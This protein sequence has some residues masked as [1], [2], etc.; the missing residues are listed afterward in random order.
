[1]SKSPFVH[2]HTHSHYSLLDGL[3]KVPEMIS[4]AKQYEMPALALTDH[5]NLYGAIEFYKTCKSEDIKP[6]IGVEAYVAARSRLDK[7]PGVDARRYHLTLLAKNYR[8][9][10][11]LIELVTRANL[12]GYY[13][14]PRVDH[15]LLAHY[16]DGIICL[17]GCFGGELAQALHHG[18]YEKGCEVART[19]KEIYGDDYYIEIMRKP[20]VPGHSEVEELLIK[21]ARELKIPLVG[22]QD[23]HYLR[24][25]DRHAHD[26][27]LNIQTSNDNGDQLTF[28]CDASFIDTEEA[29]ELFKEIPEAVENTMV[30]ADKCDIELQLGDWVFPNIETTDN[31]SYDEELRKEVL[32]GVPRRGL[33]YEGEVKERIDYELKVIEDKGYSPYF[34]VVADIMRFAHENNI[35]TSI[36]GSVAG[37][38]TTYLLGITDID[39]IEYKLPFER[40]LNP[41]RPSAPDID[42]DFADNRRD[43]VI[44]YAREKYG[45]EKVAQIGTFGTMMARGAVRDIARALGHPYAIGD[46]I[47]RLIPLGGQGFPMTI[48]KAMEM[49]PELKELYNT[50]KTTKEIIDLAKRIE[51]SVRHI[52]VHAAG[53]VIGPEKLTHYVPLQH[54]PRGGKIITQYDMHA[55]EDA[56]LLKFD[57]LG[58]RNLSI[59]ADAIERVKKIHGKEIK[60]DEIPLDD[61][62]TFELLARGET[63]GLFQLNGAGMTRYL[64]ELKPTSIHD[65]N[66]M[67]ALYRPGPMEVIPEY[68]RRKHNPQLISYPDP[69]MEKYLKESYGLI[70]YQDDL[71]FSA[72]ELAGYSWLEADKFR[73]AVGKKIPAEMAAQKEKLI[74]GIIE[75]GQTREFAEKLWDLF[76]PFQAYGFNKAHAASYGQFAYHTAY[77][78]A[79]YPTEYMAAVLTAES[80]DVEEVARIIEECKRMHI[81]VLPPDVNESFKDFSVVREKNTADKIRF[82]LYAIKNLGSDIGEAII[83][84]RKANGPY[85]SLDDFLRRVDHR[86]LNK[87]SLEALIQSGAMDS[88]GER[89]QLLAN[90][91]LMLEFHREYANVASRQSSLFGDIEEYQSLKLAD[92]PE[93]SKDDRL[94]WEKELLGLYISGHPLEKWKEK[95][96]DKPSIEKIKHTMREGMIVVVAGMIEQSR[97]VTTKNGEPMAFL[98][99]ADFTDTIETVVFPRIFSTHRDIFEVNKAVAIKGRLSERGGEKSII[100]EAAKELK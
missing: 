12:E 22:T 7:E 86:N 21:L 78:K 96:K 37:S 40:F 84:E 82:G 90:M 13:Y 47:S 14:K 76:E 23:S 67:V 68:I 26:V 24:K 53:V 65:I 62:K 88:L 6:I 51:G 69:R 36:R 92:A 1:M 59:L 87:K 42:M 54:D 83:G 2:L 97:A 38:I 34:L 19:Y 74:K 50:D 43:E 70:V 27:F 17:S 94:M 48:D 33:T 15:E 25:E 99:I 85:E 75:H 4:L 28:D 49:T 58:I 8:G 66:A 71:L 72:I 32:E 57:F 39:P 79:N 89:G 95:L 18:G 3:S 52:S 73:K 30:I 64:K 9:Y 20:E 100:I 60:I 98:Q 5:G 31:R 77:M 10:Q 91:D 81:E 56:G 44:E 16:R 63:M 80:G 29:Y 11:N 55:V 45:D 93:A 41:E 35:F 61:K 46:K